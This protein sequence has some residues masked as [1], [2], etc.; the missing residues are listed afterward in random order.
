LRRH[1][2]ALSCLE[3][4]HTGERVA[5]RIAV[6]DRTTAYAIEKRTLCERSSGL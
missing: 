1:E 2:S 3:R 5:A 6:R 4:S